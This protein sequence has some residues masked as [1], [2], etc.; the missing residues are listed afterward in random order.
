MANC[1]LSLIGLWQ[2]KPCSDNHVLDP[3]LTVHY[4]VYFC[5][6]KKDIFFFIPEEEFKL[7]FW[8]FT[9]FFVCFRQTCVCCVYTT[10]VVLSHFSHVWLFLTPWTVAYQAPLSRGFSSRNTRV[11]CCTLLQGIFL[12]QGSNPHL[13]HCRRILYLWAT[14]EAHIYIYIYIYTHPHI[15]TH[16]YIYVL[17]VYEVWKTV[18]FK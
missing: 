1:K 2:V 10:C 8:R 11:G 5:W 13:L 3:P 7:S 9:H 18:K 12:T 14:G 6:G 16:M 17:H 15:D 4:I